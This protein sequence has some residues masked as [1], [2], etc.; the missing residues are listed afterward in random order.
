[1]R[2]P[3]PVWFIRVCALNVL[4]LV[5]RHFVIFLAPFL[6]PCHRWYFARNLPSVRHWNDGEHLFY[7]LAV[8]HRNPRAFTGLKHAPRQSCADLYCCPYWLTRT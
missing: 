3:K 5:Q 1:M 2:T 7:A 6:R 8:E 4:M